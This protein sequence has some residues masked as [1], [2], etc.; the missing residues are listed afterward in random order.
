MN[1]FDSARIRS[2]VGAV[3]ALYPIGESV[4]RPVGIT[5]GTV[6]MVVPDGVDDPSRPS[7]GNTYDRRVRSGLAELGW[8]VRQHAVPGAWPTPDGANREVLARVIAAIPDGA[9]VLLDGL[10]ASAAPDVLVPESGR[11]CVVVLVHMPLGQAPARADAGDVT[12]TAVLERAVLERA[13][14][15]RAARERATLSAAVAVVTPSAW[16]RDWL[17][18]RYALHPNRI[19]VATP[20]VDAADP[21]A[22]TPSGGE[23]L[24]VAAVTPGKGHDVLFE[25]LACIAHKPWRLECVG[26]LTR[27]PDFVERIG[28]QSRADGIEDRVRLTGPL[29]CTDLGAAYAAADVLVLASRAETYGMVVTEALARGLPVIAAAVGG[30]PEAVGRGADGETPGILVP[31]GDP[32]ALAT[33]LSDWLGDAGRRL[34]LRAAAGSRRSLLSGWSETTATISRVLAEVA[35]C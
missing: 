10:I 5:A 15:E 23:L 4:G 18:D 26:S 31:P 24:C 17:L 3:G 32:A 21:A 34:R 20:G 14:P 11:L 28:R 33:A 13:V 6:H 27:D 8:S 7:G 2:R 1:G 12:E 35:A 30:V 9:V 16:S 29:T 22:G 19:H 25:A